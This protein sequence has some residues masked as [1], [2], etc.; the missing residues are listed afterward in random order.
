MQENYIRTCLT[1]STWR[2]SK[3]K[4][5]TK[6]PPHEALN[7]LRTLNAGWFAALA[8]LS[9]DAILQEV[10]DQAHRLACDFIT[11]RDVS[12]EDAFGY[13]AKAM[14]IYMRAVVLNRELTDAAI[15]GDL[16][17]KLPSPI[18]SYVFKAVRRQNRASQPRITTKFPMFIYKYTAQSWLDLQKNIEALAH[19]NA[20]D[21]ID[22]DFD[23]W[24]NREAV[25]AKRKKP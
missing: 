5:L 23:A 18:D 17:S 12:E 20:I 2:S 15:H 19:A 3:F 10:I 13:A 22:F 25:A 11:K 9:R 4:P 1:S 8:A 24:T 14:A 7:H 6:E 16:R 21:P